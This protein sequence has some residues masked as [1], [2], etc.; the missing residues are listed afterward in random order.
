MNNLEKKVK[1]RIPNTK[2]VIKTI[3]RASRNLITLLIVGLAV[4]VLI[5]QLSSL[6]KNITVLQSL[7]LWAVLI[8]VFSQ[9]ISY[10]GSGLT[11]T[12]LVRIT[13]HKLS[14]VQGLA[15][16][17]ASFSI[18]LVAG[19]MFGSAAVTYRW[20]KT[21][22]GGSDGA[23]L[24][25][26][27]PPILIDFCLLAISFLGVFH[28]VLVHSLTV[29]QAAAFIII[30]IMLLLTF[31]ILRYA[32]KNRDKSITIIYQ[33][34]KAIANFFKKKVSYSNFK[35]ELD[36]LFSAWD[37]MAT[38]DWKGPLLGT[39]INILFDALT[40]Y[41]IFIGVGHPISFGLLVTG[42]GLPLLFGKIAFIFP[43]GIGIIESTMIALY[44][45]LGIPLSTATIVILVYRLLSFWF[46]L[47][48]GFSITPLMNGLSRKR[49]A[50]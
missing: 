8:A 38:G 27:L 25:A 50:E 14:V 26:T 40:I 46:P 17:L 13:R 44:S 1:R 49:E 2:R 31:L 10:V 32:F 21:S 16:T 22:G 20:V 5:P 42:Y 12:E 37:L 35:K 24:T 43:G 18:G 4:H 28:L 29:L 15:I 41:F 48:I 33:K 23:S 45:S 30:S 36:R 39:V 11:L 47:I 9:F 3:S 19:G 7:K 34:I 6:Q